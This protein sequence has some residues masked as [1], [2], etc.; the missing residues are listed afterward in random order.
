MENGVTVKLFH[1]LITVKNAGPFLG[2]S[3]VLFE[4]HR[5]DIWHCQKGRERENLPA[6]LSLG[7]SQEPLYTALAVWRGEGKVLFLKAAFSSPI[8]CLQEV[9]IGSGDF[10]FRLS[11]GKN[12]LLSN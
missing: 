9:F 6:R 10:T 11:C 4:L 3:K 2:K 1:F 12:D 7:R 5:R 8:C